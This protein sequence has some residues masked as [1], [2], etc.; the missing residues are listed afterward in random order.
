MSVLKREAEIEFQC[1]VIA[2]RNKC[3]LLKIQGV[4]GWPDRILLTPRGRL[5]FC[6][7]KTP[8]GQLSPLQQHHMINLRKMHFPVFVPRSSEQFHQIMSMMLSLPPSGTLALIRYEASTGS[9]DLK[10]LSSYLLD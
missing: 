10:Q 5:A 2:E 6:E 3:K 7:F 9:Y 4:K 8:Q 1:R